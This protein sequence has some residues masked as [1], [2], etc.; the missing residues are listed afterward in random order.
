MSRPV[1]SIVIPVYN[2]KDSV[3]RAIDSALRQSYKE[4]E[5]IVTDNASTDGTQEVLNRLLQK[6]GRIRCHFNHENVG[7][8]ANWWRGVAEA[9]GEYVKLCFSDDWIE[10][11]CVEKL[12]L[13]FKASCGDKIGLSYCDA[14][15]GEG[16]RGNGIG[17]STS[18]EES[19]FLISSAEDFFK[20]AARLISP[21]SPCCALFRRKDLL[22]A[23][24]F[25]IPMP[26]ADFYYNR[27]I[28]YDWT[29]FLNVMVRYKY[30]AYVREKLVHFCAKNSGEP[31]ISEITDNRKLKEGYRRTWL[32]FLASAPFHK[33]F[34]RLLNTLFV[35]R[36]SSFAPG[37]WRRSYAELKRESPPGYDT[38]LVFVS[39]DVWM[40]LV[41]AICWSWNKRWGKSAMGDLL[42]RERPCD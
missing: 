19:S 4:I 36:V 18:R 26:D 42:D 12:L 24:S 32:S 30:Y 5:V 28:G 27:G 41:E 15:D 17:S 20:R 9:R 7:P 10:E 29:L 21:M 38:G 33:R 22:S 14:V 35:L 2:R 25:Y 40:R 3:V 6:H 39:R 16:G 11:T 23:F 34:K 1:V 8:V 31:C 37:C 13:P